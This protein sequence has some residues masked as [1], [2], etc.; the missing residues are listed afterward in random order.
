MNATLRN[1]ILTASAGGAIAIAS[2]LIVNFEGY[3]SKPYRDL[4]GIITVCYGHT[5]DDIDLTHKYSREECERLLH[6]DLAVVQH[7]VDPLVTVPLSDATRAA[8]YSFNYNVGVSAFSRSTLLVKLNR[9]DKQGACDELRRW[10]Y[11][12]GKAWKG[13]VTRREVEREVCL[14]Q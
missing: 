6:Q 3:E 2:V 12:A 7:S 4:A 10:K 5:G 14:G 1:K 13:L 11:A 9:G 8:L